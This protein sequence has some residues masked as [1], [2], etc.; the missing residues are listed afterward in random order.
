LICSA[1]G[2][3]LR[4]GCLFYLIVKYPFGQRLQGLRNWTNRDG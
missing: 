3:R 4:S 1:K 2:S